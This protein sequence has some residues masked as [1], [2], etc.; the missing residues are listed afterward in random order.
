M[1]VTDSYRIT[2]YINDIAAHR[3]IVDQD[4]LAH[5]TECIPCA[6]G[7]NVHGT[8]PCPSDELIRHLHYAGKGRVDVWI[9]DTA[10]HQVD[11]HSLVVE[12]L[13]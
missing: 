1:S 11:T 12:A 8:S 10:T 2:G 3:S 13:V 5:M 4:E 7:H 9:Y 6:D